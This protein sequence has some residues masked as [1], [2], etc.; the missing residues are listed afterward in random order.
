MTKLR[1]VLQI[2]DP[3]EV[4]TWVTNLEQWIKEKR[5]LTIDIFVRALEHLRGKVPDA[6]PAGTIS[7]I[8]R[9]NLRALSVKDADVVALAMGLSI[10][11]PDLIGVEND[12]II[13][14]ASPSHV[15]DAIRRQLEALHGATPV[16]EKTSGNSSRPSV[17]RPDGLERGDRANRRLAPG[18][19][20]LD[21]MAGS[22]TV[23]RHAMELGH[24]S[25]GFDTD[26]LAVL[27]ARVWTQPFDDA[28]VERLLTHVMKQARILECGEISSGSTKIRRPLR[29]LTTGLLSR[30][31]RICDAWLVFL[32]I[33]GPV[34][35]RWP[36]K[37]QPMCLGWHSVGL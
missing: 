2:Y 17:P 13:V 9:E 31:R 29:S 23:L 35:R 27:M 4:E 26:P 25:I 24:R 37:L 14:N 32:P 8:C 12:K 11:V 30:S 6:L 3:K 5:P 10:L 34:E 33:W 18:A 20:V 21:P 36:T 28:T 1:E 19:V 7:F 16:T 22:G 15:A